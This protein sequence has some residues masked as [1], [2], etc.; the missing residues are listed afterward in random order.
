[1]FGLYPTSFQVLTS[2]FKSHDGIEK[3]VIYGSRV[4]GNCREGSD[5]DMTVFGNLD[6]RE[7]FEIKTNIEESK[8]PYLVDISLFDE[9][10]SDSLKDHIKRVGK[11]FYQREMPKAK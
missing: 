2:I 4:L 1:M 3:V 6:Y 11:V 9:L 10:Q 8:I 7:L 5:I